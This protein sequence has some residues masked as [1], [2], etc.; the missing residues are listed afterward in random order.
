MLPRLNP[1]PETPGPGSPARLAPPTDPQAKAETTPHFDPPTSTSR[2]DL[3][4]DPP[5]PAARALDP[6]AVVGK[7][8]VTR[9]LGEG[10]C[11]VVV[12]AVH[13]ALGLPVALKVPH[14]SP[15][16]GG[17]S[18]RQLLRREADLLARLNHPRIV[19]L[20]DFEDD[21]AGPYL[22]LEYVDGITLAEALRRGPLPAARAARVIG[23]V[24]EG[25][26]AL[27]D[28]GI[29]HRDVK[30][31]TILVS[32]SG[33]AKIADLGL[34]L[35]VRAARA[36]DAPTCDSAGGTASYTAPEQF[37][38]PA[39]VDHRADVYAL[40]ATFYHAVTGRP[41]FRGPSA[42][43]VLF[44]HAT[45]PV[46]PPHARNPLVPRD[47]SAL[48]CRM[49]A[50]DPAQRFQTYDDLFDALASLHTP[51]GPPLELPTFPWE[52]P[53]RARRKRNRRG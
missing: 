16:T 33:D 26:A 5:E 46:V 41:P 13:R 18:N 10:A 19:H 23:Q 6:G 50:K 52:A 11:G 30:P 45:Q 35:E 25:L 29:I 21:P 42:R 20:R 7:Y 3:P 14:P 31:G 48:V 37:L 49:M 32:P 44:K 8:Q 43:S 2:P 27:L 9:R 34:A 28:L 53:R 36:E 38:A 40:G 24:A 4:P 12:R 51:A 22:V 15:P 47:V 39:T 17:P 1:S